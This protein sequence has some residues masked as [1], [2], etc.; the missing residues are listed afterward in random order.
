MMKPYEQFLKEKNSNDKGSG[1]EIS[2]DSLNPMLFDFQKDVTL[3]ALRKG[4]V[5]IGLNCG[6]GK[7]PIQLEY[8]KQVN[9]STG[10][11]VIMF[12]PPGVKTQFKYEAEKFGYDVNIINEEDEIINGINITNYER[13][14]TRVNIEAY[15]FDVY[16]KYWKKYK[17]LEAGARDGKIIIERFRFDPAQFGGIA[18]DE[19]SI[20]KHYNAK[21]RERLTR[22]SKKI[23]FR[24]CGT[25]TP[26]PNDYMELINYVDFLGIMNGKQ[27]RAEYFIQDGNSSNKFRIKR[28]AWDA[29]WKFVSTWAVIIKSPSDLG[30]DDNGYVLP[31]L[32][33]EYHIL[34]DTNIMDGYLI[35]V[36]ARKMS[37]I[38]KVKKL[39]VEDRCRL[40]ADIA[41]ADNEHKII[42]CRRNDEGILLNKLIPDS[43][44]LAGRH[45][46]E[47]KEDMLIGFA[48]GKYKILITKPE[49]GGFGLNFQ[50]HCHRVISVNVNYS[51]EE[52]YQYERRVYRFLQENDVIHDVIVMDTEGDV[53]NALERKNKQA[54]KMFN[55]IVKHMDVH[56]L[57]Q[58]KERTMKLEMDYKTDTY[59]SEY[60]KLM[61]G[62][63][64]DRVEEL[65]NKSIGC[66]V[67]SVPF[68]A[69]YSYTNSNRDIGNYND[70]DSLIEHMKYMWIKLLPKMMPGRVIHIH[71]AQGVAHQNREGYIGGWD[72]RGPVIKMM[73]EAGYIFDHEWTIEK[74]PQTERARS[75]TL[76][77]TQQ[78]LFR[79][80]VHMRP[81]VADYV[82]KFYAPGKN[83]EPINA[84]LSQPG[85]HG[86]YDA[87]N[88]WITLDMWINWAS[89]VWYKHR[90]GMK[91]WEGVDVTNVCGSL[92]KKGRQGFGVKEGRG[93]DDEKH[94]CELQLDVI[95]RCVALHSNPGDLVFDPFNGIGS[96]GFQALRMGRRYVGI[97]L[98]ESYYYTAI[99]NLQW[100]ENDADARQFDLFSLSSVDVEGST[101]MQRHKGWMAERGI[102]LYD[103]AGNWE[104]WAKN[105]LNEFLKEVERVAEQMEVDLKDKKVKKAMETVLQERM[106]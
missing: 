30:Y 44:E 61:L 68:P 70:S 77:L 9:L 34:N 31:K 22:F 85:V 46:D 10:K 48:Q 63:C 7:G 60:W 24:I 2:R 72:F 69:M 97:E 16:V 25:A 106:F 65:E 45:S 40:A 57:Y 93:K 83:Q 56:D 8:L 62:D 5:L 14:I 101:L 15:E 103:R 86:N 82:L 92:S 53:L 96:T 54:D 11:P 1:L 13:L 18:L 42:F 98:K 49:L 36:Q 73:Q 100:V 79:D 74:D 6:L 32:K 89:N 20:L 90:K 17:P 47:E 71:L 76:G 67:T 38:N 19:A 50:Q 39:T 29:W 91:W 105:G 59:E 58:K 51:S 27:C 102:S 104:K 28:P 88:G 81:S 87:P 55:E 23:P 26:A 12:C 41:N 64:V 4:R 99:K 43:V 75:N 3:W 52:M 66:V 33:R 37:E 80:A 95:E 35:P 21:T 84:L 78:T 94:L